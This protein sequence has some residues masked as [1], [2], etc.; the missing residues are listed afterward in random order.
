M[1]GEPQ[2]R[3]TRSK[4]PPSMKMAAFMWCAVQ[5]KQ[6]RRTSRRECRVNVRPP[7]GRADVRREPAAGGARVFGI[8]GT[9]LACQEPQHP[10]FV[11]PQKIRR[12]RVG[13]KRLLLWAGADARNRRLP[14]RAAGPGRGGTDARRPRSRGESGGGERSAG[15]GSPRY[16][17]PSSTASSIACSAA[18]PVI[19]DPTWS[20]VERV[21]ISSTTARS[22][23]E[24]GGSRPG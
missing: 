24:R 23:C 21:R 15:G 18:S 9:S 22:S 13:G 6:T 1:R 11:V 17:R 19:S 8:T 4:Y 20:G 12:K 5:V 10:D 16:S 2:S 7:A 3:D 14:D